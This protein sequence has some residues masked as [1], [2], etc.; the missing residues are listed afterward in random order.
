M[1]QE[2]K[3]DCCFLRTRKSSTACHLQIPQKEEDRSIGYPS[4]ELAPRAILKTYKNDVLAMTVDPISRKL[5]WFGLKR[6]IIHR[7][8]FDGT[9]KEIL[10]RFS[11]FVRVHGMT[12]DPIA[13]KLY[14]GER[15]TAQIIIVD[16][17]GNDLQVLAK[18]ND[19]NPN[20]LVID[21]RKG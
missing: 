20:S 11:M 10:M 14:L 2:T 13:R 21:H 7:A 8:N 16:L 17:S 19:G 18:C 4:T 3:V 1:R 5:L 6:N 15:W 12:V 9:S